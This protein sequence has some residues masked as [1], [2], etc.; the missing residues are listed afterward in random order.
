L[1]TRHGPPIVMVHHKM[2]KHVNIYKGFWTVT[3]L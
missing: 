1:T 2:S 3:H